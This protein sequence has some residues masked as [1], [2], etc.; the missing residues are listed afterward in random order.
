MKHTLKTVSAAFC[1]ALLL[2]VPAFAA[3]AADMPA[4][5]DPLPIT[6]AA[7]VLTQVSV[8]GAVT[9]Q[10]D[11]SLFLTDGV[12]GDVAVHLP[13][14]V[15]YIDG[16]TGGPLDFTNLK[17]G[18]TLQIWVG[19]AM[20]MSLPPQMT[21]EVVIGNV[22]AENAPKYVKITA[23]AILPAPAGT[24]RRIPIAGGELTVLDS[25]KVTPYLTKEIVTVA[26]LVPGTKILAWSGADKKVN[27]V[28]RLSNEYL[29]YMTASADGTVL[30]NGEEL[31]VKA[32]VLQVEDEAYLY[33][34]L[35]AAAEA[36]G[37]DVGWEAGRGAVIS[38]YGTELFSV[39]N[40]S[41]VVQTPDGE[42]GLTGG[43]VVDGGVTYL[44]ASDMAEFL[45]LYFYHS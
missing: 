35:R 1:T 36:A 43:C 12:L 26:D 22:P 44:P 45:N 10:E 25:A 9:K 7:D 18:D 6:A 16:T 23:P 20:T 30:L 38:Q 19:P 21:A 27:K 15:P 4:P 28:V 31:P 11:G 37:Y 33:L 5:K 2:T 39:Q 8:T 17:D 41:E 14:G 3:G 42:R 24:E 34:P 40:G 32:R 13:E 29:G